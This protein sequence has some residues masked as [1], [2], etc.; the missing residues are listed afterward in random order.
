M[1]FDD[2]VYEY[3]LKFSRDV[4]A[5]VNPVA[6][7]NGIKS[8]LRSAREV[9]TDESLEELGYQHVAL[10]INTAAR[11]GSTLGQ[12][13]SEG[14]KTGVQPVSVLCATLRARRDSA[15]HPNLKPHLRVVKS[16]PLT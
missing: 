11:Y 4:G 14:L 1:D 7:L 5:D 12:V 15:K 10:M 3:T 9:V 2:K 8:H 6:L 13:M 16:S